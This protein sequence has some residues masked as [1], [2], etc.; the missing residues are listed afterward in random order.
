MPPY[1]LGGVDGGHVVEWA[2]AGTVLHV[3]MHGHRSRAL[4]RLIAAGLIHRLRVSG[5]G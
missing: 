3:S 1:P 2:Q 5:E 4:A